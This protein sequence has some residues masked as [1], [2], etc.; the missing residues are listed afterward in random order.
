MTALKVER[1]KYRVRGGG[2]RMVDRTELVLALDMLRPVY[3]HQR[4]FKKRRIIFNPYVPS[5]V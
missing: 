2:E 3:I 1:H 5:T 4:P